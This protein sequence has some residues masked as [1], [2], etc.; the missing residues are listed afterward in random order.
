M[1]TVFECAKCGETFQG[2]GVHIIVHERSVGRI[3]P[4]CLSSAKRVTVVLERS[5]PAK[6]YTIA[7]A[8]TE[9]E[10]PETGDSKN[11]VLLGKR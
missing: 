6:A 10:L 5:S 4:A 7:Y 8:E 9:V 1:T 11:D 2:D 3:C